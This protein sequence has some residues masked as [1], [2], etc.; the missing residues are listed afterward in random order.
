MGDLPKK[1]KAAVY[2]EPGKISTKLVDLDMPEPG[3]GEVLVNLTHSGVC[4][5]DLG[6]MTNTWKGLP[7][8]TQP[9]QVGGHEGI[10]K[11]VKL[12]PGADLSNVKVGDRV[13]I[14]WISGICGSCPACLSGHDGVC[15][16]QK[17]SGYY[18]PGTFQQYVTG[19]AN[20]VT[21]IPD[22]LA[23]DAAAPML[24]AGVTVYSALRKSGAQAG[25]W[26]VLLGAGGG[27]GHLACQ[28]ASKG[29]GM[30]VIGIDAGNKKDFA[31]ECGAEVFIDHTQ[32]K[33][34]EEV[35]AATGGLGAQAVL[36]LTAANGA[37]ASGMGLLKFGGTL[38]CV[39]LPEGDLKPIATAFPQVMVAKEQ[40]IVGVA[41]GNRREAIETLQ[42]AERGV[43]KTHFRTEKMDKLN[44]IFHEMERGELKGR[45]VLD[46][47]A[48]LAE[49]LVVVGQDTSVPNVTVR[50][51]G[52]C[53]G[54][55]LLADRDLLNPACDLLLR[56]ESGASLPVTNVGGPN[57][58]AVRSKVLGVDPR[59]RLVTETDVV[60]ATHDLQG[61]KVVRQVELVGGIRGVEDEVE[62]ERVR[63]VPVLLAG[64]DELLGAHLQGV[65]L[66]AG[67]VRENVDFGSESH[68]PHDG[69]ATKTQNGDLLAWTSTKSDEWAVHGKTSTHHGCGNRRRN[70]LRDLES[71]VLVRSN[72]RGVATLREGA[73]TVL[74]AES[75]DGIRAVVFL[76][77]LA[78]GAGQVSLNLRTDTDTVTFLDGLHVL[79]DP[80]SLANDLVADA[81]R[82]RGV[83]PAAIDGV[84]VGSADTAALNGDIDIAARCFQSA[85]YL[86]LLEV[87]PF[88]LV[89]NH[90]ASGDERGC[91][92]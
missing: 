31:K 7:F 54:T 43:V 84:Q 66:L 79:A 45:V 46:L 72:V 13:G 80:D 57:V 61:G 91:K 23:S 60:E 17:V 21:P 22:S 27:L 24:C 48:A 11:V 78:V 65:F 85:S 76:V 14:K 20:Y 6:I 33:A 35:K 90:E 5:S 73:I 4:H 53:L 15:F 18:T 88:L 12:G 19:P 30:R 83:T 32:G 69:K 51:L 89:F 38:V 1:Y 63:L 25:D 74:C 26:V 77:G 37:Y 64:H 47:Q 50:D 44:D 34:E 41:V 2:D 16:N 42:F 29:M 52:D 86:L 9:G 87:L 67:G 56:S 8:P 49:D 75:V 58:A 71:E 62:R 70:A 82:H 40:K 68:S 28:I 59:Q 81:E 39:G 92:G 55:A 3:P 10:G 36:V